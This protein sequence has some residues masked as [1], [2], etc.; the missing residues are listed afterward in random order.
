VTQQKSI[1]VNELH[2]LYIK[3]VT[4]AV[5]ESL[6]RVLFSTLESPELQ[7]RFS[8]RKGSLAVWDNRLTQHRAIH[9]YG[10][11]RRVLYRVVTLA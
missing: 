9:D 6:L 2:T 10:A 7:A 11:A 5:S 3:G 4:R 8:W 1:F